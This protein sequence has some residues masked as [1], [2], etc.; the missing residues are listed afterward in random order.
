MRID[1]NLA[2][3]S[4]T[5][6]IILKM[7]GTASEGRYSSKTLCR[8]GKA[9]SQKSTSCY[10]IVSYINSLIFCSLMYKIGNLSKHL[11]HRAILSIQ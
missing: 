4:P 8:M 11:L 5:I 9:I 7:E 6:K 10:C 3:K 1:F 2:N